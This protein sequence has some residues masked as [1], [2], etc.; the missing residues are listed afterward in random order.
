MEL[1]R[2]PIGEV[3]PGIEVPPMDEGY[4]AIDAFML[5]KTLNEEG[6]PIWMLRTTKGIS[7]VELIGALDTM[8]D[9]QRDAFR[10]SWIDDEDDE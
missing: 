6:S 8:L 4:I 7:T 2:K 3:L 10:K 1:E 9:H 5:I